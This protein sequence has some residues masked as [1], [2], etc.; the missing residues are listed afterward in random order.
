MP[1]KPIESNAREG[2]VTEG[3]DKKEHS[4]MNAVMTIV[5]ETSRFEAMPDAARHH[6][7]IVLLPRK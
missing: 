5:P 4:Q 3:T 1:L 6:H 2:D 7:G